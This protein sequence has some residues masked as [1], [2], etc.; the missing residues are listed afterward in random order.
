MTND[1]IS[2]KALMQ[3]AHNHING[4]IDCN[5]IARFPAVDVAPAVHGRW[6]YRVNTE[7]DGRLSVTIECSEGCEVV[8]EI[9]HGYFIDVPDCIA[10]STAL[11]NAKR[12]KVWPFCPNCGAKMDKEAT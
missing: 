7:N 5:D 1:L 2:R 10:E 12:V 6:I 11:E 4:T 8:R 3:F 9:W